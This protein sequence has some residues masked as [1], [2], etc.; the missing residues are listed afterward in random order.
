MKFINNTL[1]FWITILFKK[2][3]DATQILRKDKIFLFLSSQAKAI[4]LNENNNTIVA[5][6]SMNLLAK[7]EREKNISNLFL[8]QKEILSEVWNHWI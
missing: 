8:N 5:I 2:N 4:N 6:F 1:S 7:I 3:K